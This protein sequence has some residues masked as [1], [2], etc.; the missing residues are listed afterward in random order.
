MP[1]FAYIF[2][3]FY[4]LF[5]VLCRTIAGGGGI[6]MGALF[7]PDE[8]LNYTDAFIKVDEK[9]IDLDFWQERFLMDAQRHSIVL[10]SR[11]TKAW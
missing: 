2:A 7:T 5:S 10:K 3:V 1:I 9:P 8:R 11:R 4:P 6:K